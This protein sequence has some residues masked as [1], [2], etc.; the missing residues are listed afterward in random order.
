MEGCRR[1]DVKRERDRLKRRRQNGRGCTWDSGSSKSHS[2]EE[3]AIVPSRQRRMLWVLA[4]LVLATM[5]FDSVAAATADTI[6]L[7]WLSENHQ[8]PQI[9][10]LR[11]RLIKEFEAQHPGVI[12]API[13]TPLEKDWV[14]FSVMASAGATPDIVDIGCEYLGS[15]IARGW[16]LPLDKYVT[17]ED[18]RNMSKNALDGATVNGRLYA[19]PFWGGVYGMFYNKRHVLKAGLDPNNLPRT[20]D[21][22]ASWAKKMN[23][24]PV[25][26]YVGIWSSATL[27]HHHMARLYS[28]G[29]D[30]LSKDNTKCLLDQPAAIEALRFWTDLCTKEKVVPPGPTTYEYQE[31]T[32]TFASELAAS[33]TN[34]LWAV[35]KL[36]GDNPALKDNILIGPN[37]YNKT[38]A[39]Y[40]K[41]VYQ[42]V[43]A[44]SKHPDIAWE[45]I[46]FLNSREAVIERTLNAYWMPFRTDV[47]DDPRVKASEDVATFLTFMDTA[48][49]NPTIPQ[50]AEIQLR[51]I[52][53]I[54]SVLIGKATPEEASIAAT[55][56][57]DL[58]LKKK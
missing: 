11:S 53:M 30:L 42:A 28:N 58:I 13:Q 40:A 7:T 47:L 5:S 29:A 2:N 20:W 36:V 44:N 10:P 3:G 46:K 45:F 26:G 41:I 33:M 34:A 49:T 52:D 22:F 18:T 1:R 6:T 43:G 9:A 32:Q 38:P 17:E 25:Y 37:P 8:E 24:P 51:V 50:I 15:A 4:V 55:R 12:I 57:I 56:D 31:Q 14:R 23:K 21:Q 19:W 35:P 27:F 39:T 54:Q 16:V 48:R